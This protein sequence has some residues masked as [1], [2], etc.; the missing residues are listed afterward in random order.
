MTEE[1]KPEDIERFSSIERN[2][3]A[4]DAMRAALGHFLAEF[5]AFESLYLTSALRALSGDA[6]VID[7]L[8]ELMDLYSRLKLL[9]YLGVAQKLPRPLMDDIKAVSNAANDLRDWRNEIAHGAVVI[10]V[11]SLDD[12]T[13]DAVAI[14]RRPRSKIGDA[15]GTTDPKELLA[16]QREQW[17]HSA[18]TIRGL[19]PSAVDLQYAGMQLAEK[20]TRYKRGEDW[21]KVSV[22]KLTVPKRP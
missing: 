14:V 17:G 3:R 20:L 11:P 19:I 13:S 22:K 7:H 1:D 12:L 5:T 4:Q 6:I 2:M 16:L 10:S 21:E 18:E 8:T 9:K 15:A